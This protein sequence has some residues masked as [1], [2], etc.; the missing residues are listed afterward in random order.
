MIKCKHFEECGIIGGGCCKI[1]EWLEPTYGVCLQLCEKNTHPEN[2]ENTEKI[3]DVL[4]EKTKGCS[5]CGNK[6]K[7]KKQKKGKQVAFTDVLKG[8]AKL[9]KSEL[10]IGIA[11]DSVIEKRKSICLG[12]EHYDFGRCEECG[13]FCASKVKLKAEKC[14]LDK[15]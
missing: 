15:W 11:K 13:C 6:K 7:K 3:L 14:P 1:G 4:R 12:C 9:L 10:N 2:E 8:G 5:G